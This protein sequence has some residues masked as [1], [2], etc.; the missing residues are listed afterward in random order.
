M[1]NNSKENIYRIWFIKRE[2]VI[3][4][5]AII[6]LL[7]VCSCR[8]LVEVSP[9]QNSL[10]DK[11]VFNDNTTAIAVL[12]GMHSNLGKSGFGFAGSQSIS[13]FTG[14]SA[15]EFNVLNDNNSLYRPY[16][17]NTLSVITNSGYQLWSS[18]YARIYSVNL[19][20]EGLNA[21][22]ELSPS[23]RQELLGEAKFLRG[24]FY[25]YLTNLYGDVPLALSSDY[26][27]NSLL[28]RSSQVQVYD[29]IITDLSESEELLSSS[30]LD[31]TLI[32]N[33]SERVR[34]TKW[35]AK[36]MLARVYLYLGNHLK[37]EEK[38]SELINHTDLF[39]LLPLNDVFLKN[40]REAIWQVQPTLAGYNT[41]DARIFILPQTGP[42]TGI[43]TSGTPLFL[44]PQL[45]SDFESQDRRK[46][47]GNWIGSRVVLGTTYYFPYKYKYNGLNNNINA[48]T[49]TL[50]MNEYQM[51]LRLAE[52]Y[53]IRAEARVHLSN[54]SGSQN[55]LNEIRIRA[56]LNTTLANNE[57]ALVTAILNERRFE[58]FT[59]FGHRWLDL[60]RTG[61]I[62]T[63][64]GLVTP[65]KS[66]G[67][68]W[69]SYQQLYPLAQFDMDKAPNLIQTPG[70]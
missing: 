37:A 62:N 51:I 56:G 57:A 18:L 70:Y 34:P 1:N 29:Q 3:L 30:Y 10:T 21:S 26:R 61:N 42:T 13:I 43:N 39:S 38:A 65:I 67:L 63:I 24:F 41:E 32:S 36:A 17:E 60:K 28:P 64:M 47:I 31:A 19:S 14:L 58:L 11:N 49:G 22:L 53:L 52:M 54:I 69:Q 48:S 16:F 55:D 45:Y 20:I 40:S 27:V 8:K 59:E 6:S 68:A 50:H 2:V 66:N 9:P 23:I 5:L 33:S 4:G 35:A 25:F 12:S 15:D 7:Y 46:I 44:S